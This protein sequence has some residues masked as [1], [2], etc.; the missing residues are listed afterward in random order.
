MSDESDIPDFAVT[1]S[2]TGEIEVKISYRIIQLFSEGL[3]SSPN[4]A[5][6]ELVSN[7]FDAGAENVHVIISPDLTDA[8]ATI[9]VIDDGE[10]MDGIGL[11][12]H[13][14]IGQ[15][16]KRRGRSAGPG[17]RKPIGKFGIGK[18]ATYVLANR[19]SH[20]CKSN[21]KYYATSMDYGEIPDTQGEAGTLEEK[22]SLPLRELTEDEAKQI[23][24][25][26]ITG[27]KEGFKKLNLFSKASKSWTVAIMSELKDMVQEIKLGRLKWVLST[28]MPIRSDFNLFLTGEPIKSSK[29]KGKKIGTWQIGKDLKKPQKPASPDFE[30]TIKR[31][32]EPSSKYGLSHPQ[33]GRVTGRVELYED[34]LTQGK[35]ADLG[36]SWGIFVYVRGR[37]VNADD[38]YFGISSNKLRHGTL[39]R[40]RLEISIDKLDDEL[41]SSRETV[42]ESS[43]LTTARN[44]MEGMFNFARRKHEEHTAAEVEG[45][46]AT[47]RV[48]DTPA[49]LTS[50]PLRSLIHGTL[51]GSHAPSLTRCPE[52]LTQKQ[53]DEFL[54]E[55]DSTI[56]SEEG[57]IKEIVHAA[58]GQHVGIAV[59]DAATKILEINSLHPFVAY[60][61][62]EFSDKDTSLPLEL[63][64]T[65]EVLLEASMY[66]HG[67]KRSRIDVVMNQ[68]D[69]LL[70]ELAR[71]VGRRNALML[72]Q[73]LQNASSNQDELED[74]VIAAFDSLGFDTVPQS[75]KRRIGIAQAFVGGRQAKPYNVAISVNA[76]LKPGLQATY[77]SLQPGR[78]RKERDDGNPACGHAIIVVVDFPRQG[79]DRTKIVNEEKECR[80]ESG[81]T[82]TYIHITDFAKLVRLAPAKRIGLPEL[83]KL[84]QECITPEECKAW[85][86]SLEESKPSTAP[87]REILETIYE[88]QKQMPG[89][90]IEFSVVEVILRKHSDVVIEKSEIVSLCNA[91][92]RIVPEYVCATEDTV[93]IRSSP[94]RI[95]AAFNA[96]IKEYPE[97][98]KSARKTRKSPK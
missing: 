88:E 45:R 40:F 17:K 39:S 38:P 41:R 22:V 59:F 52:G 43:Q 6:E 58:L 92:Q 94:T 44:L 3:Y 57:P 53:K 37:L 78:V 47:K 21:G 26:W 77:K 8:D 97:D 18:L 80:L 60:F 75:T 42:R 32:P 95:L 33:L 81:K 49:R 2:P 25:P 19:L 66:E 16:Q 69:Q 62:D 91:L 85:V 48:A 72:S 14:I 55:L 1:G 65:S 50:A 90:D 54:T 63:L 93:A 98:V 71:S 73:D 13:W 84:F 31:T 79:V 36:R 7:S 83:Q 29:L 51:D 4:K 96:T 24:K 68:R 15:S 64:A 70:R 23:L 35:S 87:Y 20:V 61:G 27:E 5:I 28:A 86:L 74:E 67:L 56:D 12:N 34:L 76:K 11:Q 9:A 30:V 10:G 46:R 82:A 89:Q